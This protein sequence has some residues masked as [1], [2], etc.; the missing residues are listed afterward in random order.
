MWIN[1]CHQLCLVLT[2]IAY[3]LVQAESDPA[4]SP[5]EDLP[6]E[7]RAAKPEPFLDR[8]AAFFSG[9]TNTQDRLQTSASVQRPTVL[10]PRPPLPP[11]IPLKPQPQYVRP[12]RQPDSYQQPSNNFPTIVSPGPGKIT[13]MV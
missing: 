10:R 8:I 2:V 9:A 11:Q 6:V 4:L 3:S 13:F 5:N 12:P 7:H 1:K